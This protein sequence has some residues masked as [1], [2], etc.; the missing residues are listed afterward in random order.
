MCKLL[1]VVFVLCCVLAYNGLL[2]DM[3]NCWS[4][5]DHSCGWVHERKRSTTQPFNH[6]IIMYRMTAERVAGDDR[7]D[8]KYTVRHP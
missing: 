5:D 2:L 1:I 6:V 7:L 4:E 8:Y 3:D